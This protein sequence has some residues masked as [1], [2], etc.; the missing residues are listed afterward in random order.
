VSI[1]YDDG[2][3]VE[4]PEERAWLPVEIHTH[5]VLHARCPWPHCAWGSEPFNEDLEGAEE[6]I[7]FEYAKHVKEVHSV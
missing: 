4:E 6:F 5:T 3:D 7:A 1:P 2:I